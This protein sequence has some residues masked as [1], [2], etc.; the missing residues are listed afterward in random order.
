M[1]SRY[2]RKGLYGRLADAERLRDGRKQEA[3]FANCLQRDEM[4]AA[5]EVLRELNGDLQ[6]KARLAGAAW[7][8][9]RDK[10]HAGAAK[11]RLERRELAF[12][13]DQRRGRRRDIGWLLARRS[14][15]REI[16]RQARIDQLEEP[17][18]LLEVLQR[19]QAEINTG[20]SG[21][22]LQQLARCL[23][24]RSGCRDPRR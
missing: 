14:Q 21:I 15:R 1:G 18:R 5:L 23:D 7:T 13:S 8:G 16:A 3:I 9:Q 20:D 11:K 12:T 10:T 24:A 22:V 2:A 17:L 6:G 4:R 19:M